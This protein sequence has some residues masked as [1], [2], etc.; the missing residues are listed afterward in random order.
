[1]EMLVVIIKQQHLTKTIMAVLVAVVLVLLD[2]LK[3]EML[4]HFKQV[5]MVA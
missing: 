3:I 2:S 5:E 4:P 1:M